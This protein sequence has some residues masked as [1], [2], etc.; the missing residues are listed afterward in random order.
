MSYWRQEEGAPALLELPTDKPRPAI[1]TFRGANEPRELS[2]ELTAK[3]N[4]LSRQHNV[5]LFMLLLAA[6]QL[7]LHR[8]TGQKDI[9]VASAIAGRTRVGTES[10]IGYFVNTLALRGRFT[11][12]LTVEE[13]LRQVRE[14]TLGA[15]AH[16]ELP[17]E[18]LVGE[19]Q[20]ERDLSYTPLVQVMFVLQNLRKHAAKHQRWC[21]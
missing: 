15:Y 13:L 7:L 3:L 19:L 1:Q 5:T 20:P 10:L 14:V 16:Q 2:A 18:N 17:F 6:F 21:C 9:V 12:E 11:R 4:E 8:Y